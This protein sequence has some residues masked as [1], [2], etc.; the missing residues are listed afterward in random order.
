[1]MPL[2]RG[3][4]DTLCDGRSLCARVEFCLARRLEGETVLG[5]SVMVHRA[6]TEPI[7]LSGARSLPQGYGQA[8][9]RKDPPNRIITLRLTGSH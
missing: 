1:M 6:P 3:A 7:L 2:L 4:R 5:F 8:Q 9:T